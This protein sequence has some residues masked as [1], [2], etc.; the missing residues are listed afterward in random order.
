MVVQLQFQLNHILGMPSSAIF[1]A[2]VYFILDF[3]H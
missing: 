1:V 2:I 3:F